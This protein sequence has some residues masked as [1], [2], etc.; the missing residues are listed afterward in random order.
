MK[1]ALLTDAVVMNRLAR[2]G[3]QNVLNHLE[4][5]ERLIQDNPELGPF[6]DRLQ[7]DPAEKSSLTN[8]CAD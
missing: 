6:A 3:V 7:L 4:K 1:R 5:V 2:E 8:V